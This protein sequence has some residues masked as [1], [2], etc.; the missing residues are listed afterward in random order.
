MKVI[1]MSQ[2]MSQREITK[3]IEISKYDTHEIQKKYAYVGSVLDTKKISRPSKLHKRYQRNLVRLSVSNPKLTIRQV[4]LESNTAVELSIYAIR[5]ILR[6]SNLNE[7]I[8]TKK[9]VVKKSTKKKILDKITS[10][11]R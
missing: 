9:S 10:A 8:S 11:M 2:I 1:E 7:L 4:I 6:K 3:E 5:K